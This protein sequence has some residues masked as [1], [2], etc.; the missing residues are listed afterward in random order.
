MR[1]R[2]NRSAVRVLLDGTVLP[3][4]RGECDGF[5]GVKGAVPFGCRV[6]YRGG[7]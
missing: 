6:E 3:D 5:A 7:A 2:C 4:S 1:F